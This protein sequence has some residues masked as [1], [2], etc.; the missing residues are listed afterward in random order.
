MG[1][2]VLVCSL[3]Q[4]LFIGGVGIDCSDWLGSLWLCCELV[5]KGVVDSLPNSIKTWNS[6]WYRWLR[7]F[8][9]TAMLLVLVIPMLD[10]TERVK[11]CRS[12]W[13]AEPSCQHANNLDGLVQK[14]WLHQWN[15]YNNSQTR[16]QILPKWAAVATMENAW[17]AV[18]LDVWHVSKNVFGC[19]AKIDQ[20]NQRYSPFLSV[21]WLISAVVDVAKKMW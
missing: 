8:C 15:H 4:R 6:Y 9:Q 10:C 17:F 3:W 7:R 13:D 19:Q 18:V 20:L 12:L 1:C 11:T 16:F 14:C 5:N 2:I 21:L